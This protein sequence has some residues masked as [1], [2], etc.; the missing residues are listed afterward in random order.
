MNKI[1]FDQKMRLVIWPIVTVLF[2]NTFGMIGFVL[3][4]IDAN[5]QGYSS[6]VIPFGL[7]FRVALLIISLVFGIFIYN[8]QKMRMKKEFTDKGEYNIKGKGLVGFIMHTLI[9]LIEAAFIFFSLQTFWIVTNFSNVSASLL[10]QE[11]YFSGFG[12]IFILSAYFLTRHMALG[13]LAYRR[14]G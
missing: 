10:M 13:V 8:N 6:M 1:N 7:I 2:I 12:F 3:S 14:H 4:G 9:G 5:L 11:V